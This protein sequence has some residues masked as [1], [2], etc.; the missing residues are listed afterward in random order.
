VQ[1]IN[2]GMTDTGYF[3]TGVRPIAE[4][5][6]I[7]GNDGFGHPLSVAV[8]QNPSTAAVKGAFKTPSIR[9][10]EFT[11]PY[12]HNG[13]AATLEQVVDF[14]SRG[15]DFPADG[16]L[17]PGIQKLGLSA[18]EQAALVAFI[19]ATTDDRVRYEKAPFDHP[20]LCVPNGA[21]MP[22]QGASSN[23]GSFTNE[24]VDNMVE[25]PAVGASGGPALQTFAELIGAA[26]SSGPRAH[27]MTQ[28]C[29]MH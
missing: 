13:G 19:K 21:K 2:A 7:A 6:G 25:I 29:S 23:N 28:A 26:P 1:K 4:D 15:G 10:S 5:Q 27:D 17:G 12:F 18:S 11:G 20:Q 14:Y 9:N 24:A 16:N 8:Q 22:I 3:R